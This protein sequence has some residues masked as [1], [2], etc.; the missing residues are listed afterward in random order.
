MEEEA[1]AVVAVVWACAEAATI[2]NITAQAASTLA[3]DAGWETEGLEDIKN[4]LKVEEE[5]NRLGVVVK[6][7]GLI[8]QQVLE[9]NVIRWPAFW[10]CKP[11]GRR[12]ETM[13]GMRDACRE[14]C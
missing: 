1:A 5:N 3:C 6:K 13:R 12:R 2:E 4:H 14:T 8:G 10:V 9:F 7:Q 11:M